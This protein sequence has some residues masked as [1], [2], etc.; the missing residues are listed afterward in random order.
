MKKE[1]LKEKTAKGLFW[2]AINSGSTQILNLFFGIA[3]ARLLSPAD[4]GIVGVLTIFTTIAGN[5]QDSG[6]T[7]GLINIK[8]PTKNDYNSVFWFNVLTSVV[9]YIILFLCAPLISLF[10]N[11]PKLTT[12]SR[13]TF[14]SFFIASLGIVNH[15]YLKKNMMNK[16]I[17]ICGTAA[18]LGSGIIGVALAFNGYAY[19]SLAWQQ[20]AYISILNIGRYI[21]TPRLFYF[22]FDFS[23]VKRMFGFSVNILITTIISTISQNILTFIFGRLYPMKS[24]GNFSQAYKW[25]NMATSLATNTVNQIAQPLMV[26]V[27][28]QNE[29]EANIFRKMMR[30]TAFISFPVMFGLALISHE[31]IILTIGSKWEQS[32]ILLQILCI[33]GAFMPFYSLYQ[34]LAI[35]SGRS[36][37][38]LRYSVGLFI[39][40]LIIIIAL[41][42]FDMIVM[43]SAYSALMIL[44]LIVWQHFAFKQLS[45]TFKNICKDILP[46][47]FS[48]LATMMVVYI[49][50]TFITNA[51]LL[52]IAKII[53][54]CMIYIIIM[55]LGK[56]AIFRESFEF[57]KNRINNKK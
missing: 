5:I 31:F 35:S 27:N 34:N 20:I 3:L 41:H 9:L 57:F 32:V 42:S 54:A 8:Q 47:C 40:Q 1:S 21:Y 37:I 45:I 39:A 33:G 12:L 49:I 18:L 22:H 11:E 26:S 30:F 43:V 17:A 10:F 28:K 2:G 38:F 16:E 56:S 46:Y 13:L 52:L 50:T 4:Y 7:Q 44:W 23:P 6:F 51:F 36:D 19:W 29:R 15:A 24:V 53:L 55:I 48:A 25:N 14:L